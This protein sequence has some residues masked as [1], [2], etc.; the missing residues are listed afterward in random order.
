MKP[1]VSVVVPVYNV[2]KFLNRCVD[3]LLNQ[4]HMNLEII[5]VN[6][7][8]TDRSG[9]ICD[10]YKNKHNNVVVI[11]REFSGGSASMARNTGLKLAS[12][13]YITFVDSDDWVH[14]QMIASLLGALQENDVKVA[15][16]DLLET[17]KYFIKPIADNLENKTIVETR[18]DAFKRV[19]NNQ[20]FSVCVRLYELEL[21]KDFSF[22]ENVI[23]EDV[24]FTLE[25]FKQI[26]KLVRIDESL[27]YYYI[28]PNSITRKSYSLKY[29]DSLNSGLHLQKYV[30]EN[31]E[32]PELLEI[33]QRHILKKLLYH[34]KMLNYNPSVDPKYTNRKWLKNLID[35]NYFKSKSH[36]SYLKLANFLS[37]KSFEVLINFN[38][39]RH[40]IFKTNEFS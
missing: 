22:P 11:H 34:Y 25:V 20:R 38:K 2:E 7:A 21:V 5:L 17:S 12:G 35:T 31:E 36:D 24:F 29:F 6:D 27:Y 40:K 39:M 19:I 15:E 37:V 28:T 13:K 23:S 32:D 16:C 18:M 10:N 14:P 3:S 9:D 1:K 4:S 8:S 26:D 33:T 30:R